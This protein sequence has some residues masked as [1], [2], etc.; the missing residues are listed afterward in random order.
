MQVAVA[1]KIEPL[2][3]IATVHAVVARSLY[4]PA[5]G[6]C[7][8]YQRYCGSAALVMRRREASTW[9]RLFGAPAQWLGKVFGDDVE[10][11]VYCE[12]P[13]KEF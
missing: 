6:H 5:L 1:Q 13:Q 10:W 9:T 12:S 4:L 2:P 8:K 11:S 3:I 7:R